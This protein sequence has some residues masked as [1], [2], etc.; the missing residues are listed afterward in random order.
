ML[1]LLFITVLGNAF[2]LIGVSPFVA[3]VIKGFVL[4]AVVGLDVL[5]TR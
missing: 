2:N 3:M 4:V 5:R 1:G